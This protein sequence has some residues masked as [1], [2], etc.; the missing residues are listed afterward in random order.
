MYI[1]TYP[2]MC[3]GLTVRGEYPQVDG[4]VGDAFVAAR[5]PVRLILD[6]LAHQIKVCELPALDVQE[7]RIFCKK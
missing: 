7:F 5:H 1:Y 4:G 3:F 2:L 6:L